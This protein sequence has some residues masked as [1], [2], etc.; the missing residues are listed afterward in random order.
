MST[1]EETPEYASPD[2]LVLV[3]AG[4][5]DTPLW[6]DIALYAPPDASASGNAVPVNN[7]NQMNVLN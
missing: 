5:L 1:R 3:G 2:A 6:P 4:L 7:H